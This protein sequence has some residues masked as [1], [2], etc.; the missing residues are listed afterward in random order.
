MDVTPTVEPR[1]STVT[2]TAPLSITCPP[3]LNTP[4]LKK[5]GVTATLAPEAVTAEADS[6]ETSDTAPD[7]TSELSRPYT[8]QVNT[9]PAA[10]DAGQDTNEV[11]AAKPDATTDT[12]TG[13]VLNS[14]DPSSSLTEAP[15]KADAAKAAVNTPLPV[16]ATTGEDTSEPPLGVAA[17]KKGS[18]PT[19]E[20]GLLNASRPLTVHTTVD[21]TTAE[22]GHTKV[23][24]DAFTTA[25]ARVTGTKGN[26]VL[27]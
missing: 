7:A 24:V 6:P 19:T 15:P 1:Y 3:N 16:P 21:D 9:E 2:F 4:V 8:E 18:V 26:W 27:L 17:A 11:A 12:A 5:L 13:P 14:A 10:T 23:E 25:G 20:L 22:A